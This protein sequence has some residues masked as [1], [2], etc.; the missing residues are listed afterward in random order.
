MGFVPVPLPEAVW[1]PF[2]RLSSMLDKLRLVR[3]GDIARMC[4][5]GTPVVFASAWAPRIAE[6]DVA[7]QL[8]EKV[9][10]ISLVHISLVA[11]DYKVQERSVKVWAKQ[12]RLV[13]P[14]CAWLGAG[15]GVEK[16]TSP[17][18]FLRKLPPERQHNEPL[19]P[20]A[21]RPRPPALEQRSG[22]GCHALP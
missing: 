15:N 9:D 11:G 17:F 1:E 20:S 13:W 6:K 16:I 8:G 4:W 12:G 10:T 14:G 7:S 19:P 5:A 2:S 18:P 3:Q 22:P 21:A